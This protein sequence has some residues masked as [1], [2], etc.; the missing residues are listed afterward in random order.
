MDINNFL[1]SKLFKGIIIGI[2]SLIVLLFVFRV[3]MF[4]GSKRAEFAFKWGENYHRNFAGPRGGFFEGFMGRDFIDAHGIFG[5]IIKID[6]SELVIKDKDSVEKVVLVKN[7]TTIRRFRDDVKL[8]D[9]KVNDYIVIIG[10]PN[11]AGQIEAKLIRIMPSPPSG[12]SFNGPET[13][14]MPST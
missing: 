1:E 6:G 4:I 13:R 12:N 7:D 9:L 10:D 5:Q 11:D 14:T 2:L 8:S 3:G